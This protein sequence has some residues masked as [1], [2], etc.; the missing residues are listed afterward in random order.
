MTTNCIHTGYYLQPTGSCSSKSTSNL[1]KHLSYLR[2]KSFIIWFIESRCGFC[3][4]TSHFHD[5]VEPLPQSSDSVSERSIPLHLQQPSI[6]ALRLR[7]RLTLVP[8]PPDMRVRIRRF[9]YVFEVVEPPRDEPLPVPEMH[10]ARRHFGLCLV[11]ET[12]PV[13]CAC[14]K[15]RVPATPGRKELNAL[16]PQIFSAG[17]K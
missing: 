16:P 3:Q 9:M 13:H 4:K 14:S 7:G 5:I 15:V 8:T 12:R 11:W 17:L 1:L 2:S 6:S 10:S